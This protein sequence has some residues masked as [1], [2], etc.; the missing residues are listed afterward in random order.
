MRGGVARFLV[1]G[2][3]A[4]CGNDPPPIKPSF[5][6]DYAATYQEVRNCRPS[7]EHGTVNIRVLASPDALVPYTGRAQPFPTGAILLKEEYAFDDDA[8]AGPIR[9]WT[10][11]EKLDD[12]SAPPLLDWHWQKVD[13]NRN[14]KLN[15]DETCTTCH[16][17]CDATNGWYDYTCTMP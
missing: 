7:I 11:M 8:C 6:V 13:A 9:Y 3:F 2:A 10:M 1:I 4:G 17:M 15:D 14:V 5:P 16:Q 12:G